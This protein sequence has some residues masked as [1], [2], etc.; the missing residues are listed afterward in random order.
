MKA[1]FVTVEGKFPGLVFPRVP[2]HEVI[3]R[4][5]AVGKSISNRFAG[6][7][8][9]VGFWPDGMEPASPVRGEISFIA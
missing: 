3:G 1:R 2:G 6:Q 9:G 7:R 5:D 8:V 4:I